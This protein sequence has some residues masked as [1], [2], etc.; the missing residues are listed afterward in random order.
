MAKYIVQHR[1]GTVT[2]WTKQST[3]IPKEGEI[4]IEIDELNS[5]H[6]L[7]IGDGVH[8]Y[9]ELAYL[10]VGDEVVTQVLA[11]VKPRVITVT[12]AETWNQD[13]D[14][15][16]SQ[17]ISLDDITEHSRLDLQPNAD[18]IAEFKQLGLVFVTENKNG[19]IT[20]Y[21]VGNMPSKS[22]AMQATIVETE[23]SV[24]CDEIIGIPVGVPS[25]DV[26]LSGYATEEFVNDAIANIPEQVQADW[27]QTDEA[28]DDYI[29]NKPVIDTEL[30]SE[31]NN[32]V[33]NY[34]VANA[35]GDIETALDAILAIQES[36]IPKVI[37]TFIL[38]SNG[39]DTT[40][41]FEEGMTWREWCESEYNTIGAVVGEWG[42]VPVGNE[43][44]NNVDAQQVSADERITPNETYYLIS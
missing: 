17:I 24:D 23:P 26:D 4:V 14:G 33:A 36:L 30:N 44:I 20:V 9:A 13:A 32:A 38:N 41:E 40:Y 42:N 2:Q 7:K 22:Y 16:Y 35:L 12:L 43:F 37:L 19:T 11:E 3:L 15:K 29:K 39:T 1:R 31:S 10:M 21:S 5:L 8:T 34:V 27:T 6:K 25:S 18:M 28:A